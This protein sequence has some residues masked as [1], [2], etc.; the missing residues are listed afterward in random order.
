[1]A[2]QNYD[3]SDQSSIGGVK[4]SLDINLSSYSQELLTQNYVGTFL[5]SLQSQVESINTA[6]NCANRYFEK[7]L[8]IDNVPFPEIPTITLNTDG[9]FEYLISN[10]NTA[11]VDVDTSLRVRSGA[12]TD[13]SQ[14]SSL[15]P[16]DKVTITGTEGDWSHVEYESGK[17]GYVK[18]EYLDIDEAPPKSSSDFE[19]PHYVPPTVQ[20]TVLADVENIKG[21]E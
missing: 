11:T 17:E 14:I 1:M 18:T 2:I 20:Q 8:E 7:N 16:G 4:I 3:S 12:G 10:G 13:Y 9:S 5:E 21:D 19:L 15:S 6:L